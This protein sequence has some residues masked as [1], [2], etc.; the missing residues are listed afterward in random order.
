MLDTY[1]DFC[2][3]VQKLL[4]L[5]QAD[6]VCEWK[7]RC[8]P[9]FKGVLFFLLTSNLDSRVHHPLKTWIEGSFALVGDSCHPTLPHLAQVRFVVLLSSLLAD[10]R[11]QGAAQAVE[12]A[13]VLGI[14]LSKL[15]DRSGINRALRVYEVRLS[16]P[17]PS[18]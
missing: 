8:V 5:V 3:R 7:L 1:K 13:G 15:K 12:D 11:S 18:S 2:P 14:V 4:N 9:A 17:L 16:L 6:E 10:V